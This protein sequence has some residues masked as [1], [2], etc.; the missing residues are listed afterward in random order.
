MRLSVLLCPRK[1]TIGLSPK[2]ASAATVACG[3]MRLT[4]NATSA[5]LATLSPARA[6]R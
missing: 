5:R 3:R 2:R 1:A 6:K 4:M